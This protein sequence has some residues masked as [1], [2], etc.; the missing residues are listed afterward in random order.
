MQPLIRYWKSIRRAPHRLVS[1]HLPY[2]KDCSRDWSKAAYKAVLIGM[3]PDEE[4]SWLPSVPALWAILLKDASA[5]ELVPLWRCLPGGGRLPPQL[6]AT[7]FRFVAHVGRRAAVKR[8]ASKPDL[9]FAA[10]AIGYSRRQGL[11]N[12]E[13]AT[14]LNLLSLR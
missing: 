9:T 11:T 14:Q 10:A 12:K 2:G 7:L 6:C 8:T 13:I 5:S 4:L 1:N 3:E